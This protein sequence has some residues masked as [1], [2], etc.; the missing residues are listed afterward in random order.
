MVLVL[1]TQLKT[2]LC[3]FIALIYFNATLLIEYFWFHF[4]KALK[5]QSE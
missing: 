3:N 4:W 1:D 5:R 2:S